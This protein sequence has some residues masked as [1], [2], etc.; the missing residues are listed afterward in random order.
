[1]QGRAGRAHPVL[2]GNSSGL[3]FQGQWVGLPLARRHRN[4]GVTPPVQGY[5]PGHF[6]EEVREV[7]L[8][9]RVVR[10][11]CSGD[12]EVRQWLAVID[13]LVVENRVLQQQLSATGRRLRLKDGQRRDLAVL[14]RRLK[15]ALRFYI[16]IVRPETI[17]VWYRR[18]S[19]G[20]LDA[21][22]GPKSHRRLRWPTAGSQV[23]DSR[24]GHEIHCFV[25]LDH[26]VSGVEPVKLPARS[27]NL[28]GYPAHCTSLV[29]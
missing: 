25:R 21:A 10:A 7:T 3:G 24:P 14:G 15:P 12:G 17:M 11:L 13:Y 23:S 1:M 9:W 29:A 20:S 26:V 28:K 27:P 6:G 19:A 2:F 18:P 8:I 4:G 16:N 5:T 22:G